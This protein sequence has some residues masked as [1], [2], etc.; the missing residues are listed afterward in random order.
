M[1][2]L[3][4][5]VGFIIIGIVAALFNGIPL[6]LMSIICTAGISL[7][8]WIPLAYLVGTIAFGI[9][10]LFTSEEKTSVSKV[11]TKQVAS[12]LTNEQKAIVDYI[13]KAKAYKYSDDEIAVALKNKGWSDSDV[14]NAFNSL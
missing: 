13:K 8:I 11:E 2:A 9:G 12:A 7:V 10:S 1:K 5:L 14:K 6:I 4:I 3:K